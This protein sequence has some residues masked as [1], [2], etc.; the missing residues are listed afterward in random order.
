MQIVRIP[1]ARGAQ[2]IPHFR[3]QVLLEKPAGINPLIGPLQPAQFHLQQIKRKHLAR[4]GPVALLLH[5][6]EHRQPDLRQFGRF[7]RLRREGRF[8]QRPPPFLQ[9]IAHSH[10]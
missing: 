4:A 9:K 6:I 8:E 2:R 10:S 7:V 1:A 5:P 3:F